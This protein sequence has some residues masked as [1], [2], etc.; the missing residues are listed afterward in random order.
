MITWSVGEPGKPTECAVSRGLSVGTWLKN[1]SVRMLV[2]WVAAGC[3]LGLAAGRELN[4]RG[5]SAWLQR[6]PIPRE[7]RQKVCW[8]TCS[9]HNVTTVRV[10]SGADVEAAVLGREQE[11]RRR[12]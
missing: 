1:C 6:K 10:E 2:T 3:C 4:Q 12:D 9:H 11:R 5:H 7:A 8:S